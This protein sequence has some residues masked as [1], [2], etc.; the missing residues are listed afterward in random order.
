MSADSRDSQPQGWIRE[1]EYRDDVRELV[2]R[3][4]ADLGGEEISFDTY[5]RPTDLEKG[6]NT[7]LQSVEDLYPSKLMPV[8]GLPSKPTQ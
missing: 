2:A 8:L 6:V 5:V 3:E 7:V 4:L 1:D